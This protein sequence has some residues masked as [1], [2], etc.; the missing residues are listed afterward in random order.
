MVSLSRALN[1]SAAPC[2]TG[3]SVRGLESFAGDHVLI[4]PSMTRSP[5]SQG[6]EKKPWWDYFVVVIC[7]ARKPKFFAEGTALRVVDKATGE[8]RLGEVLDSALP[9]ERGS[10]F[11]GGSSE[12]KFS[13]LDKRGKLHIMV[14]DE[15]GL[16]SSV[17]YGVWLRVL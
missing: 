14:S 12:V 9:R 15:Q 8:L 7:S 16:G 5:P 6:E 13:C 4:V 11:V 17:V 3:C 2:L 10:V 1:G